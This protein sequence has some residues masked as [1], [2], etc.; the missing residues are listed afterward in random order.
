MAREHGAVVET[1]EFDKLMDEQ[2]VRSQGAQKKETIEFLAELDPN[3]P[4]SVFVGYETLE[5]ESEV[6]GLRHEFA[7]SVSKTPFYAPMGGQVEDWGWLE[8]KGEKYEIGNIQKTARGVILHGSPLLDTTKKIPQLTKKDK[9]KLTVD[10][11]RRARIQA[12]HSGTHIMHWALRKVLG[13]HVG[14][15]GSYVGPD[16]LR[17]DFTHGEQVKPEQLSEINRLVNEHVDAKEKVSWE[18]RPYAQVK[19]DPDILQ[20]FGDKYGDEVRVVSVGD[21]SKEL[22]GGTHVRNTGEIGFFQIVSEGAIAAGVRRVEA[23][24]GLALEEY[25][26]SEFTKQQ[27]HYDALKKRRAELT[28][29]LPGSGHS[30]K[31]LW[32]A[33]EKRREQLEKLDAEVR[34]WDKKA[35]KDREAQWQSRAA[36]QAAELIA[37][38]KSKNNVPYMAIKLN[39][40]DAGYLPV[41]AD[42]IK[43][44]WKGVT[45]LGAA[46]DGKATLLAA[47]SPEFTSKVQAGKIIQAIAPIIGGKGGGRPELAQGGGNQPEKL[48]E[49]LAKVETLL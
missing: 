15:K 10:F 21:Y 40:A 38:A 48:A 5:I 1:V 14:Q 49:A 36:A 18:N 29:L 24:S 11:K 23:V 32:T 27:E 8:F 44:R 12:H 35:A 13:T 7:F 41:L 22:C 43:N 26:K 25:V 2:R 28:A 47:V 3:E 9:V 30:A 39:E 34:E 4:I 31:E 42:A 16:R 37:A 46:H 19:G 6:T 20:F 33:C 45:V 17:F